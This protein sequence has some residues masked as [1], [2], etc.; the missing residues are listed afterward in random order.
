M[1]NSIVPVEGQFV[2]VS[3]TQPDDVVAY[4]RKCAQAIK[5]IIDAEPRRLVINTKR[6]LYFESWQT[7]G[8][9]YGVTAQVVDTYELTTAEGR[10]RGYGAKANAIR[11]GETIAT[12]YSECSTDEANW[13]GRDRNAVLSMSQTRAMGKALRSCLAWVAVLGGYGATTAEEME[14]MEKPEA[15]K[16][17]PAPARKAKAEE[18][19]SDTK[20]EAPTYPRDPGSVTPETKAKVVAY[21]K[22]DATGI[23]ARNVVKAKGWELK[24]TGDLSEYQAQVI[25]AVCE[26]RDEKD[27][28]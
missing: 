2:A 28:L 25:V 26:G 21:M 9:F 6:Y 7:I 4:A 3:A 24:D 13:R 11:G 12:A 27:V 16:A 14:G 17:R 10:F 1:D 18:P 15:A 23:A 8:W 22:A 19:K 5:P 20:P